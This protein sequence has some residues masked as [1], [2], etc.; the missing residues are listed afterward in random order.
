LALPFDIVAVL[1]TG[2]QSFSLN[3]P[4]APDGARQR[5]QIKSVS[6]WRWYWDSTE[7]ASALA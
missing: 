3:R 6:A 2:R 1:V 4:F 5:A 7:E